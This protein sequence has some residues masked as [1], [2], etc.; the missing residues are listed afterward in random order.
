M[1][2]TTIINTFNSDN[3]NIICIKIQHRK[4]MAT[5]RYKILKFELMI[6]K[7]I[8]ANHTFITVITFS[9]INSFL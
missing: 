4:I 7:P 1:N 6:K 3:N 5:I 9:R 2:N 8:A